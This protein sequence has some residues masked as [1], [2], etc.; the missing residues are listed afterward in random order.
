MGC[1]GSKIG[2]ENASII[3]SNSSDQSTSA[4]VEKQLQ[5]AQDEEG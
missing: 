5:I 4:A 2:P 3:P 1:G